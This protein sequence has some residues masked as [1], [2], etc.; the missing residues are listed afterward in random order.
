MPIKHAAEKA[1]RQTKK[2]THRNETVRESIAQFEKKARKLFASKS[3][4]A[5]TTVLA[6]QKAIDKA[7]R[8]HIVKPNTGA[9]WKS[10]LMKLVK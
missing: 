4:D 8:R 3:A 9:R 10:R 7:V 2:R 6:F 5:K 1:L